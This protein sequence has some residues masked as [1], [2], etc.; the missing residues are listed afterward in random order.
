M[1]GRCG[2]GGLG[3]VGKMIFSRWGP[4]M[5]FFATGFGFASAFASGSGS[6][7]G[8][9]S[10]SQAIST[11]S[12]YDEQRENQPVFLA[13]ISFFTP[14]RDTESAREGRLYPLQ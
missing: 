7:I 3:I 6:E 10:G 9:A 13:T 2:A 11:P 1:G 12:P 4:G 5:Y 14:R 8:S